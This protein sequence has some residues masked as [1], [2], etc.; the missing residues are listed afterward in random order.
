VVV[1]SIANVAS[2]GDFLQAAR[3]R[4]TPEDVDLGHVGTRRVPGLR[5]E[6]IAMLA[7][8]SISYYT[9]LEQG[10]SLNASAA[11]IDAL[12]RAMRLSDAERAHAHR[13]AQVQQAVA[14]EEPRD[15]RVDPSLVELLTGLGDVPAMIL[16]RRRDILAW[17]QAG[18]ALLGAHIAF[19]DVDEPDRRPNAVELV[20][21]DAHT[22]EL[23]V[24]WEHKA[25]SSVGH[26]RILASQFP[27]DRGLLALIGHLAV[28]SPEF[29]SYWGANE[30]KTSSA[31]TYRMRHPVV[32]PLTVTQQMLSTLQAPE[33]NVVICTAPTGSATSTALALLTRPI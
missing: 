25:R 30:I 3:A 22:R 26:L 14:L 31:A 32:G 20:F 5:R 1:V 19:A 13:L 24:D 23:Y 16:G 12:A 4:L 11:V 28:A 33:Q 17:N 29:A 2:L 10:Q 7:G 6:E 27:R 18:H 9:R 15:E 21:L 8:V